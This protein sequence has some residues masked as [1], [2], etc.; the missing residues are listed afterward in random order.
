[1]ESGIHLEFLFPGRLVSYRPVIAR[2]LFLTLGKNILHVFSCASFHTSHVRLFGS[3]DRGKPR[4]NKI[5]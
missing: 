5:Q 4:N 2:L 1:M 3:S